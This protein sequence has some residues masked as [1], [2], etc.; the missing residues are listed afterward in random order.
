MK[1]VLSGLRTLEL[2]NSQ[3]PA[4][5]PGFRILRTQYCAIC[6]TDAKMWHQ[7]HR[8]LIF[9]RVPGHEIVAVDDKENRFVIWPG[10][11]CGICIYCKSGRE[12]LCEDM[13]ILGF[14][15]DGG[16]SKYVQSPQKSLVPLP[17]AISSKA[18]CF[19]EPVGCVL[20]V[21]EKV[22]L[23]RG[24]RVIIYGGG[25]VGLIAAL[26][27]INF[28]AIPQVIEKN[29]EKIFSIRGFLQKTGITCQKDTTEADFDVAINACPDPIAFCLCVTKLA[30]GGRLGFFSGLS[31]NKNIESN[32]LN[33][34]H[35]K[36]I[37]L[38]GAYGLTK[39]NM[40]NSLTIIGQN[41]A[42]YESLIEDIISPDI[43]S[44]VIPDILVGKP[45]KYLLDFNSDITLHQIKNL[46]KSAQKNIQSTQNEKT[47]M[48]KINLKTIADSITSSDE[49]FIAAAQHKIDNK[50]K[51]LGA[52]GTLED[53]AVKISVIQ[54]T[55]TPMLNR[56][57][58]FVFAADHGIVEEGVSA[59][60]SEVTAQMVQNFLAGGAAINILCKH[61][62]IDIKII[63]AGVK[64]DFNHHPD[65]VTKK[66]R[67]GTRNFAIEPAMTEEEASQTVENGMEIFLEENNKEKIDILGLGEMGIGNT[68]A[69][70]AII[71]AVTG[72]AVTEATGRG[73]GID[74][75]GLE[76]KSEVISN[77]LNFHKLNKEN[78]LE[79]L[80]KV[81]GYEIAG[82]VGAVLAAASQK[83]VVVLD[84][85]ISTAAGLLA[86]L[87]NPKVKEYLISGHKS[88]EVSQKSALT[89]MGLESVLDLN[90]RL[91]EG[92]GAAMTIDL[93]DASCRIMRDMA[94]FEDAGV[95]GKI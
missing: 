22:Q 11:S 85:V 67:Q 56:K 18:A 74:D 58:L 16:F 82:I 68:T 84:G 45:L 7:G 83:T 5:K 26:I 49:S 20:N 77:A 27:A 61:N 2:A 78:G 76:H 34:L 81:G 51:P 13:K 32:L 79:I 63:D 94:S 66:V 17:K 23:K 89:F 86:Y 52:L 48:S 43:I 73:T 46:E 35:Y 64:V 95:S 12:N 59:F 38:L 62:D 80:Q 10:S 40:E 41:Q 69:A 15:H 53:L 25:T 37:S 93:V 24:E 91:G 28:G 29:E 33:L 88:V 92:T 31:K 14:H 6:K 21:L 57:S 36:E 75:K 71:C 39:K 60:P 72:L 65:L 47:T 4:E 50:T 3:K 30:K 70:T 1:L 54:N 44:S 87:I 90:M 8:D 19:A 55:L 42:H 9:P